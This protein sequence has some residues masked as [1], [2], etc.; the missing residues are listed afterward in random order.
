[1]CDGC[2]TNKSKCQTCN[3]Q[4]ESSVKTTDSSPW[5]WWI[6]G[7]ENGFQELGHEDSHVCWT[8]V[9][10][11]IQADKLYPRLN[12]GTPKNWDLLTF[13]EKKKLSDVK[14]A[15][16]LIYDSPKCSFRMSDLFR[17]VDCQSWITSAVTD[18]MLDIAN[19]SYTQFYIE[20]CQKDVLQEHLH[21]PPK[22]FELAF[23]SSCFN[24]LT[25]NR[26]HCICRFYLFP[27]V[28]F[29]VV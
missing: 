13:S 26:K 2:H 14:E 25:Q 4:E 12:E 10:E 1:M 5:W 19:E 27:I 21:V 18:R 15:N 20:M 17:L 24:F 8:K 9:V 6:H 11:K 16:T 7:S 3:Y 23:F 29:K 28:L 22:V